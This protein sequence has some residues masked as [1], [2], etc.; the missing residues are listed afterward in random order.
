MGRITGWSVC[1]VVRSW[2]RILFSSLHYTC[3]CSCI[4]YGYY[5]LVI[6]LIGH[7]LWLYGGFSLYIVGYSLAVYKLTACR[8]LLEL[9]V[10][11][12]LSLRWQFPPQPC[13]NDDTLD[14]VFYVVESASTFPPWASGI[15]LVEFLDSSIDSLIAKDRPTLKTFQSLQTI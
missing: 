5:L 12:G 9:F 14:K 1:C 4:F 2:C 11:S 10:W 15:F 8:L 6:T 7:A 3:L 13:G